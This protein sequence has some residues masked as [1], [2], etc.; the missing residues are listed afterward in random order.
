MR[1]TKARLGGRPGRP[2]KVERAHTHTRD[3]SVASSD[4]KGKVSASTRNSPAALAESPVKQRTVWETRRV[5]DRI[6]TH[7]RPQ[8]TQPKTEARVTRQ[9]QPHRGALNEYNA[10]RAQ[11]PCLGGSQRQ[12]QRARLSAGLRLPCAAT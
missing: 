12:A 1:C 5:S 11:L 7:K 9:G 2:G 6:D 10:E 3:P 4:P 8:H